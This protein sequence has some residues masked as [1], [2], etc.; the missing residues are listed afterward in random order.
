MSIPEIIS[1]KYIQKFGYVE[2]EFR[3]SNNDKLL[4]P[5]IEH[6]D[7]YHWLRDDTRTSIEVLDCIKQQN[8]YTD[9]LIKPYEQKKKEIYTRIKSHL[10]EDYDTL[11]YSCGDKSEYKYFDSNKK[12]LKVNLI[13]SV[14]QTKDPKSIINNKLNF[15]LLNSGI[16]I[17]SIPEDFKFFAT[18][19][20]IF[21]E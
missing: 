1:R 17:Q 14:R 16:N 7:N 6:I 19:P 10:K 21:L 15:Y 4:N 11:K 18:N 13:S 9:S 8:E 12:Y 2:G 5:P 3:G 20:L